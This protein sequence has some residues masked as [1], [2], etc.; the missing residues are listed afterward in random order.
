MTLV[1]QLRALERRYRP[2]VTVSGAPR[3]PEGRSVLSTGWD[4]IDAALA[5]GLTRDA[6]HEWF[7]IASPD[8]SVADSND[9][10]RLHSWTPPLLPL[11]HLV[12]R[13]LTD[14]DS[15]NRVVWIGKRCF[16][17]GGVL[18]GPDGDR[19]RLERCI[20]VEAD[21]PAD[22]LWAID[23][24]LRCAAVGV[25]VADGSGF[26]MAATRRIQ[27]VAKSH[28]TPVLLARPPWEVP[29]LSAAQTRWFVRWSAN[30]ESVA[31]EG[32]LPNPRWSVA[33]L[34]CKGMPP[35]LRPDCWALEWDRGEGVVRL[36]TALAGHVGDA[37]VSAD[38]R[39]LRQ[40]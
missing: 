14:S 5:G 23:L 13:W 27:L 9:G 36:S 21:R 24:A 2:T 15:V 33:L 18:V 1:E 6:L 35:Q 30:R 3:E 32:K 19:R 16:P 37:A 40:A 20:F 22:R 31:E 17:H 12:Q 26:D 39:R 7:G 34:R 28:D 4:A 25:V 8:S 10:A 38:G 11:V 29:E